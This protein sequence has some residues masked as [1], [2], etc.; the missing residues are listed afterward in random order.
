MIHFRPKYIRI[1]EEFRNVFVLRKNNV[2]SFVFGKAKLQSCGIS[3][4]IKI[5]LLN[6][7]GLKI[8]YVIQ[9]PEI[10]GKRHDINN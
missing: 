9:T 8:L 7:H 2:F 4:L 1:S 5:N 6:I 3:G 10:L